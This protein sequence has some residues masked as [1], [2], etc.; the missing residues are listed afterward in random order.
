MDCWEPLCMQAYRQRKILMEVQQ[1]SDVNSMY[2]LA[3][4]SRGQLRIP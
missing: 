1:V 4:T 3:V 2:E